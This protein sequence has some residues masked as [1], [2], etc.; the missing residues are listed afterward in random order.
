L[1]CLNRPC[2]NSGSALRRLIQRRWLGLAAVQFALLWSIPQTGIDLPQPRPAVT[3]LSQ[4]TRQAFPRCAIDILIANHWGP[5]G[6]RKSPR[7]VMPSDGIQNACRIG[8]A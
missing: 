2:L 6:H 5:D 7:E 8:R 3:A 4:A 1:P